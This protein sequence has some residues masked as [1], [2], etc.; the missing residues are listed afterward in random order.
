MVRKLLLGCGVAS[1]VWYVVT[2][3]IGTLRYPGYS[4]ADQEFSELLAVGSPVRSLMIAINGIPYGLLVAAF[5]VGVWQSAGQKRAGRIT[6]AMLVAYAVS[7]M[8]TGVIFPM[9]TR[10]ALAAGEAGL[11]N[12]MHPVGTIVMSLFFVLAMAFGS[13]L[14]GRRFQYYTY[15]TIAILVVFGILTSL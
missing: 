2:D 15:A 3:V 6:A 12:A 11:R 1:S 9:N 8:V 7:G 10:E 13:R 4:Y 14:L 5:A